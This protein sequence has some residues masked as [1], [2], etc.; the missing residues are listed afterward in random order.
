MEKDKKYRLKYDIHTHTIFSHGKGTIE[1]NVKVAIDRGVDT[2][3]ISDHGPGHVSYGVKRK[4][5]RVMREEIDRLKLIYPQ[6]DILLGIE[7]N[8]I[9]S[10]GNLDITKEEAKLFDYVLAGYH[11]GVFGERPVKALFTHANNYIIYGAMKKTTKRQRRINTDITVKALYENDIK[12]LTH[13]G[14]K[15]A[16]DIAEISKACEETNT[17]MEISTWHKCLTIEDIKIAAKYDVSFIIS[18]DAHTPERVGDCLGGVER[19]LKAGLDLN[20][21]INLKVE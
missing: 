6:I 9:N 17:L 14:D 7:A 16:F 18:S 19:A 1:D 2:I 10:S 5:I 3:G 21:I 13:P 4:N 8:I 12:I 15:G 11:Y 20:R